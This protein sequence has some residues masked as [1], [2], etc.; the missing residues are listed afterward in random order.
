M[1]KNQPDIFTTDYEASSLQRGTAV[2]SAWIG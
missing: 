1:Q 2:E